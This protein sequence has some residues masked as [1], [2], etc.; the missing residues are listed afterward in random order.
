MPGVNIL[1][2]QSGAHTHTNDRGEFILESTSI[3]DSIQVS[4]IGYETAVIIVTQ[5]KSPVLV[6]LKQNSYSLDEVV[7]SSG[8]DALNVFTEIDLKVS[9]VNSSQE[10]LRQVPG[11]FIGQ[12]AGGGKAEQI[13]LR[14][15]DV[16]HGTD[17][18]IAVDGM[19]VNLVS[20][21]HGQGYADLH[22]LIPETIERVELG[23]GP[24][25]SDRGNFATAGH[26]DLHT[27]DR[28]AN[29][30]VSIEGGQFS[31]RR[32]LGMFNL[33]DREK[34]NFYIA[35]ESLDSD[36]PFESPQ[37][38]NRTNLMAKYAGAVSARDRI[39]LSASTFSSKWDASGQ[40]PQRKVDDGTISRFGAIDDTEG[41][42]TSR[43]NLIL[44][45]DRSIDQQSY[46]K[47]TVYMYASEFELYS[48]FTFFLNDSVN[49]DQ[50]RQVEE[51][52][53]LGLT[54]EYGH[55][56]EKQKWSGL[57]KLGVEL[58]ND[59]T[60]DTELS[61]SRNRSE[62]LENLQLGDIAESNMAMYSALT[63]DLGAFTL[64]PAIRA[65]LID[66][67]Y[68]NKLATTYTNDSR[69]LFILSPKFNVLYNANERMQLYVK[70]G[71]G[72][73]SNDSRVVVQNQ[74]DRVLPSA[75]GVDLGVNW[76]ASP[77]VLINAALW[78]LH[79]EQE[80]VYVGDEGIVEPSGQTERQGVD[81][82]VRFQ[83]TD[84]LYGSI[85]ANYTLARSIDSPEGENYIP[86]APEQSLVAGLHATQNSGL[87]GGFDVRFLGDR[88][89][90]EDR[91]IIAEGYVVVDMNVGYSA[92]RVD[93]SARVQ[94][95]LD[96]EWNET[97]FATESRLLD[98]PTSTTEI[99]FTPGT[100]FFLSGKI[101][102]MF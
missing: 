92:K 95:L 82:S 23:K 83:A 60:V 61:H 22:F 19:P 54:S 87:Y 73:H 18:R 53:G 90:T 17:V 43:S 71:K 91:S 86:L 70:S 102:Y 8:L 29:S 21:A 2:L 14:G 42:E 48:N 24:Y 52:K 58:R 44:T 25:N 55:S 12:H 3:S 94:N 20:H 34:Q 50:I 101:T 31:T 28:L 36:G 98:E 62:T 56:F 40:I 38:F 85:D 79:L 7:I 75:Y 74:V 30:S 39:S 72:F 51:R 4:V 93:V 5:L 97:Q 10:V 68:T 15:F 49:G 65:D 35:A 99:H 77:R 69:E 88:A 81:L 46:V 89:A 80:F 100:P 33:L 59:K 26:V 41:G 76:K 47:S 63:I 84:W 67:Q 78:Q 57:W 37:N 27:K 11:L 64:A 96:T 13:F 66:F 16:D 32:I 1:N 45:F 9:P 6:E